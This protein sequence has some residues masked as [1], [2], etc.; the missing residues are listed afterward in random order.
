MAKTV[1]SDLHLTPQRT[2]VIHSPQRGQWPLAQ[3]FH[4]SVMSLKREW[5]AGSK[6]SLLWGWGEVSWVI[7]V[8]Q[9]SLPYGH[10]SPL[11]PLW[12]EIRQRESLPPKEA[13]Q[14]LRDS[15][16]WKNTVKTVFYPSL[17]RKHKEQE[18][19]IQTG[20]EKNV[21][22]KWG[23]ENGRDFEIEPF[24]LWDH[25]H[26]VLHPPPHLLHLYPP[27]IGSVFI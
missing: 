21:W 22:T 12:R 2:A 27:F 15:P 7:S 11:L 26:H 5:R 1:P 14:P 20:L 13:R 6:S 4:G 18:I 10:R 16:E 8:S 3:Q 24:G 25:N 19:C 9:L 23:W 17:S